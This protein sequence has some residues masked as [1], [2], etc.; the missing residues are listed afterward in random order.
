MIPLSAC[1]LSQADQLGPHRNCPVTHHASYTTPWD[2]IERLRSPL[3]V[4]VTK[5]QNPAAYAPPHLHSNLSPQE[6]RSQRQQ[7]ALGEDSHDR[8]YSAK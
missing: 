8:R 7:R 3:Y 6:I 4:L 1:L 2:T 5:M